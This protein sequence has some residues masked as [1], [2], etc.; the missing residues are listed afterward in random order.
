MGPAFRGKSRG[1][2]QEMGAKGV[3]LIKSQGDKTAELVL[4]DMIMSIKMDMGEG[5]PTTM[6]QQVPPFV[7]QGMKEDGSGSFGTV[8]RICCSRCCSLCQPSLSKS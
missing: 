4:K 8:P 5:Y 6:E 2:V 3:L 1:A 7:V